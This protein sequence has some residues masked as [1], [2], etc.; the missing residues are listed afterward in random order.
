VCALLTGC[1]DFIEPDL[2]E[3]GAPVVLLAAAHLLETGR[4]HFTATLAPAITVDGFLRRVPNDTIVVHGIRLVPDSLARNG[5]RYYDDVQVL[6]DA[7]G[8]PLTIAAPRIPEVTAQAPSIRWESVRHTGADTLFLAPNEDL[9]LRV[10][11]VGVP[12]EPQPLHRQWAVNLFGDEASF[13]FAAHGPPPDTIRIP[14]YWIPPAR[15]GQVEV[16]LT[17]FLSGT[18]RPAPGD[19]LTIL[20]ADTRIRWI[21]RTTTR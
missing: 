1:Y 8:Q 5:S 4:L 3:A 11:V 18:Y 14:S 9:L 20:T 2:P 17:Y 19:Y 16:Y 21:V 6:P 15:N 7:L 13:S 10:Q 12:S